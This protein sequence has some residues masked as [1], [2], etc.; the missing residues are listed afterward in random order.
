MAKKKTTEEVVVGDSSGLLPFGI[1]FEGGRYQVLQ[2]SSKKIAAERAGSEYPD[3]TVQS[4]A[5]V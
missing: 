4:I 1:T 2:C 5:R 3:L